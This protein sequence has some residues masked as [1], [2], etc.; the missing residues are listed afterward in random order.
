MLYPAAHD[1]Q[2]FFESSSQT[3]Q[4]CA[5]Q[6]VGTNG[7]DYSWALGAV[8]V[9]VTEGGAPL[10]TQTT[11]QEDAAGWQC[12]HALSVVSNATVEAWACGYRID[13]E[14]A[15]IA[16]AMVANAG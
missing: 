2:A 1:A 13:G 15:E 5:N 11:E 10:L 6:S 16:T 9:D 3:W 8:D 12:Q 7:G 4:G 14:A